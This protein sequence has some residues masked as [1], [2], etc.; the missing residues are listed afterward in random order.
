MT[1]PTIRTPLDDEATVRMIALRAAANTEGVVEL[2]AFAIALA[3]LMIANDE[4]IA[5]AWQELT[6]ERD[7]SLQQYDEACRELAECPHTAERNSLRGRAEVAEA[8]LEAAEALMPATG[9]ARRLRDEATRDR[10][11]LL[12]RL[13]AEVCDERTRAEQAEAERDA[14]R[15]QLAR[16]QPGTNTVG[17]PRTRW[18]ADGPRC[19]E[20]HPGSGKHGG[21]IVECGL[22]PGHDG[23]HVEDETG[24]AWPNVFASTGEEI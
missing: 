21:R 18:T 14:L 10:L 24:G 3:A 7:L 17:G 16:T 5:P 9:M 15:A 20:A 19:G 13:Q 12:D 1:Q 4:H 8:K 23:H 22:A 6:A 2:D 11:R